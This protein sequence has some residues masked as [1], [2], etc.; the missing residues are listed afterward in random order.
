VLGETHLFARSACHER[1]AI[2]RDVIELLG[3]HAMDN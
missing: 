1:L 2:F 3:I